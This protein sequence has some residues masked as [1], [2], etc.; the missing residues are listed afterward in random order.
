MKNL[1]R[2]TSMENLQ[3]LFNAK[4]SDKDTILNRANTEEQYETEKNFQLNL[5]LGFWK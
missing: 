5:S 3:D 4:I 1:I 2:T